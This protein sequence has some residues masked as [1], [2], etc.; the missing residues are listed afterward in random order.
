MFPSSQNITGNSLQPLELAET[1]NS[2]SNEDKADLSR[3]PAQNGNTGNVDLRNRLNHAVQRTLND[4][5]QSESSEPNKQQPQGVDEA[6]CAPFQMIYNKRQKRVDSKR[7]PL[8]QRERQQVLTSQT[9]IDPALLE[10]QWQRYVNFQLTLKS[11]HPSSKQQSHHHSQ[12]LG[13]GPTPFQ[14]ENVHL[15]GFTGED[16]PRITS[17]SW[18]AQPEVASHTRRNSQHAMPPPPWRSRDEFISRYSGYSQQ[19]PFQ[20]SVAPPHGGDVWAFGQV[21]AHPPPVDYVQSNPQIALPDTFMNPLTEQPNFDSPM[22][23]QHS[24]M[25][26]PGQVGEHSNTKPQS[27]SV[28]DFDPN[29]W[30]S[31]PTPDYRSFHPSDQPHSRSRRSAKACHR[32]RSRG[33]FETFPRVFKD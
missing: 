31:M 18:T 32:I 14:V 23:L 30:M 6:L 1:I 4:H 15:N 28:S 21:R 8:R 20:N 19:I 24:F 22:N 16:N 17:E 13:P 27:S 11:R 12:P 3:K 7:I 33:I 10:S 25:Q 5:Q 2:L 9:A 26:S 29:L